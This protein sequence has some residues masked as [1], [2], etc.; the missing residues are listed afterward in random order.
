[1]APGKAASGSYLLRK[2]HGGGGAIARIRWGGGG[3]GGG[4]GPYFHFSVKEN[5]TQPYQKRGGES[6]QRALGRSA[7]YPG[8]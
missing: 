7:S 8:K 1:M 3:G 4:G 5:L 6:L 2:G